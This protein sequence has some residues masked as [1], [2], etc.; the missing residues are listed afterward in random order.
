[1]AV[2]FTPEQS[3]M[4]QSAYYMWLTTVRADGMPQPTPIWFIWDNGTFLLY[5]RPNKQK[6]KNISQNAKVA[7][8]FNKDDEAE[9]FIVIL[10]EAAVDE[11]VPPSNLNPAYVEKYAEGIK[12]LNWT[13]ESMAAMFSV[14]I[15]ITPVQ[16][17][18]EA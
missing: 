18:S 9:D 1:M 15:R 16:V 10:G 6:L 5:S 17:R 11:K 14:P 2:E 13:P 4:I 8:S 3:K 7:L 12:G